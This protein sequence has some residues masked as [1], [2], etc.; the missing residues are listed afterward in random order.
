MTTFSTEHHQALTAADRPQDKLAALRTA[1]QRAGVTSGKSKTSKNAR[2]AKKV[3]PPAA[4]GK[5]EGK[6]IAIR[7]GHKTAP[8][9]NRPKQPNRAT[10][11]TP[12]PARQPHRVPMPCQTQSRLSA[13]FVLSVLLGNVALRAD[14]VISHEGK[15]IWLKDSFTSEGKRIG[16]S[17]CC[18]ESDPC[19][20]HEALGRL[21]QCACP[22]SSSSQ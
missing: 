13:G 1:A 18:L 21:E 12:T 17:E 4:A 11:I 9:L 22:L 3:P 10:H 14:T 7:D 19:E 2:A 5:R 8:P 16:V 6:P 15:Q 20:W